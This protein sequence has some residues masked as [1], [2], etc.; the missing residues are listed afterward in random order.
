MLRLKHLLL[1]VLTMAQLV[2]LDGEAEP[3][4]VV[5]GHGELTGATASDMVTRLHHNRLA[6][7]LIMRCRSVRVRVQRI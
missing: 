3:V 2:L 5:V 6:S 1:E 7:I 4:V